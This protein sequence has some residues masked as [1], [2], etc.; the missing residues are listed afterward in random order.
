MSFPVPQRIKIFETIRDQIKASKAFTGLVGCS[1][2]LPKAVVNKPWAVIYRQR[3]DKG[4][5]DMNQTIT[6]FQPFT[7][8]V[9]GRE[10]DIERA[11]DYLSRLWLDTLQEPYGQLR[12]LGVVNMRYLGG[13]PPYDGR[14]NENEDQ[15]GEIK[16]QVVFERSYLRAV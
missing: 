15:Y 6:D 2:G 7:I 10:M 4:V 5:F 13:V 8:R 1:I 3:L 9:Y 14:E 16:M 11:I 12:A